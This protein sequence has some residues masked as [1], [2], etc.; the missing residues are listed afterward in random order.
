MK[1]LFYIIAFTGLLFSGCGDYLDMVPEKDIETVETIFERR[2]GADNWLAG[3]YAS[4]G[5]S[6]T[7]FSMNPI[8]LGT[9]E[10]VMC[11]VLRNATVS[12][13]Q[14]QFP[15]SNL[16]EGLQMSQS[17]YGNIWDRGILRA[18][19]GEYCSM[20][21]NIRNCNVFLENIGNVYDMEDTEKD[22]WR[23]EVLA[24]KAYCYFELIRRYGPIVLVPENIS[25]DAD[26]SVIY[27]SRVHVDTCFKAVVD[28][29]DEAAKYLLPSDARTFDRSAYFSKDAA[30]ALKAKVLLYAASPLFNG[31]EFYADFKDENGQPLFSTEY[32]P[33]K[34]R[35]AAVA[36]D[37]AAEFC[38]AH[39]HKLYSGSQGKGSD[40]LNT[41]YDIEFSVHSDFDNPEFILEWKF[42]HL[43]AHYLPLLPTNLDHVNYDATGSINPSMKMV[44]MYYTENG[45]PLEADNTW[46]YDQRYKQG[47]ME[48]SAKY[49]DVV[50][51]NSSTEK[52]LHLHLRREPRFY[53]NIAADRTYWKRGPKG[54]TVNNN[55]LVRAYRNEEFGT[56]EDVVSSR[57]YQNVNGYWL[58]K[59]TYSDLQTRVY[60]VAEETFPVIRLAEVYLMQ[61]E[62]WNEY[63]GPS[64]K[65]Y[66]PLNKVRERA[67][68]PDVE[69]SW[70]SY[71]NTP[72]KVT[73]KEGMR[74]IIRQEINI[75]FAFEGHRFFNL[76]RWKIAHEELNEH[77]MGWNILGEDFDS[78]Y[79]YGNGPIEVE[80]T[81]KF[82]APRDYLFP[83]RAEDI[84]I[85]GLQ[86]N[87]GW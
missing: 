58:K 68:I 62:A 33:E 4:V 25:I 69:T 28:L 56:T 14:P 16:A 75:E 39:G 83:L 71:S 29:L 5:P 12:N 50:P 36:A 54:G 44:E 61:A 19:G 18:N 40:L 15:G 43:S 80:T 49:T 9:D 32:D 64:A 76:R 67:G 78:F 35:L 66:E 41:M 53:A 63:E 60:S 57:D 34:W 65:V 87:P 46:G 72:E 42:G 10:I 45:L 13:G 3:I 27:Q 2:R 22:Q 11:E 55:L 77:P 24:L 74:D 20:Y 38:E 23:G 6:M 52:I 86:Q 73:T 48:T 37:S 51:L 30:L 59:F 26:K 8:F 81:R 79:N 85:S 17:P 1:R 70:R 7:D 21:E 82:T 84:L 31:N 47:G